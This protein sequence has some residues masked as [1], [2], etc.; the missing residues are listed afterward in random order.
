MI[1]SDQLDT[2]W[3]GSS[4]QE[5][6]EWSDALQKQVSA[7]QKGASNQVNGAA[8]SHGAGYM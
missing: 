1:C 7:L 6:R 4:V 3:A 8:G 2:L 5:I